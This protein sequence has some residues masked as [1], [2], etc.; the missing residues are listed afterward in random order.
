MK[1]A[2]LIV[3]NIFVHT[4]ELKYWLSSYLMYY[5]CWDQTFIV[6]SRMTASYSLSFSFSLSLQQI[7]VQ[8][9]VQTYHNMSQLTNIYIVTTTE[10]SIRH[11][12]QF[13]CKTESALNM[14]QSNKHSI[15]YIVIAPSCET[16]VYNYGIYV[17]V[18]TYETR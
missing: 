9:T 12:R 5:K 14:D 7:N 11:F 10:Y 13:A 18:N 16:Y 6:S 4:I 3:I 8:R 1:W 2:R 15:N 17:H